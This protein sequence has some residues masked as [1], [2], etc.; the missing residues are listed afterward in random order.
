LVFEG[1]VKTGEAIKA[2]L[3]N[4]VSVRWTAKPLPY[5]FKIALIIACVSI[6]F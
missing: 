5:R 3:S 1:K 2:N 6:S 4:F